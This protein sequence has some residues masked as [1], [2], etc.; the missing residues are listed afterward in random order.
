LSHIPF[1][2]SVEVAAGKIVCL[3]GRNGAG[4]STT[5]LRL[6]DRGDTIDNGGIRFHGTRRDMAENEEVRRQYSTV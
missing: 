3:L 2:V 1:G 5:T 4:K 6:A